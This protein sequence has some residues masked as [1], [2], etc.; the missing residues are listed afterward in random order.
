MLQ[1][2]VRQPPLCSVHSWLEIENFKLAVCHPAEGGELQVGHP[3]FLAET[4][5]LGPALCGLYPDQASELSAL[6][7][8]PMGTLLAPSAP[9]FV[10]KN[11]Y[12]DVRGLQLQRN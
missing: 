1:S 9:H 11:F 10:S 12:R 6:A 2:E 5:S 4:S 3:F 8:L 7:P